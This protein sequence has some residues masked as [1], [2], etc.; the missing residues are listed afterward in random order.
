MSSDA[1]TSVVAPRSVESSSPEQPKARPRKAWRAWL[2]VGLVCFLLCEG[3]T[4]GLTS[5][6]SANGMPRITRFPL[7]PYR[8]SAE[9]VQEHLSDGSRKPG[10]YFV[11]DSALGWSVGPSGTSR[12]KGEVLATS[13]AQGVR[14]ASDRVYATAPPAGKLRIVTVGD[15]FTHCD[16]VRNDETWQH[17][18]E[19]GADD[20][21]VLNLGVGGYGS[22]QAYLRWKREGSEFTSDI[23]ILGIWP[24]DLCR[25]VNVV[26]YYLTPDGNYL[27]KPRFIFRDDELALVN[28]P[29]LHGA[30]LA[31]ALAAPEECALLEHDFWANPSETQQS[32][33]HSSR[34]WRSFQ[35]VFAL[36]R[37]K[38]IRQQ[39]YSGHDTTAIDITVGIAE[40]FSRDVAATGAIPVVLL[41]PMR[42]LLPM[43][44][45]AE[46]FPLVTALESAGVNVVDLGPT[47][48]REVEA[49]SGAGLYMPGGH[50]SAEGNRL[51][52]EALAEALSPFLAEAREKR[53]Q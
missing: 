7:V 25:N 17:F 31:E 12:R 11:F 29:V 48:G 3:V 24:E 34:T 28:S 26:R 47:F 8:P 18:L 32:W 39:L 2:V 33:T 5:T 4:R 10:D 27:S 43:H 19:S 36:F 52:S 13:N 6:A 35:S 45:G 30:P 9:Q 21:E 53:G 49:R 41:I 22:D 20:L 15:S 51:L 44:T 42:D 37:R 16:E 38:A 23:V 46:K 40:A 50:H 14:A 1:P